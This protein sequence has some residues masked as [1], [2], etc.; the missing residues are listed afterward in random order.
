MFWQ[1]QA[2]CM[3][4]YCFSQ[5]TMPFLDLHSASPR[6]RSNNFDESPDYVS[7]L[8]K[9]GLPW[10]RRVASPP[11]STRRSGPEPS[12]QINVCS[13]HHQYSSKVSPFQAKTALESLAMAAAAWSYKW[14]LLSEHRYVKWWSHIDV[15]VQ[16]FH[17]QDNEAGNMSVL[18]SWWL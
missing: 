16:Q 5:K 13:V 6:E 4:W 8:W 10:M 7:N 9:V 11:S 14:C 17:N 3:A 18:W 2:D 15:H 12:G 1:Q